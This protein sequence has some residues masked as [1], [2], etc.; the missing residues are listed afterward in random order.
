MYSAATFEFLQELADNNQRDWFAQH[1]QRYLSDVLAPSLELVRQLQKPLARI[2]PFLVADPRRSGGSVLRIYRDTRFSTDK[3]PYK[4]HVGIQ[5]RHE[6]G[7]DIHAPSIYIQ[8][9]PRQSLIAAGCYRPAPP[10]LAAIRSSIDA[11]QTAWKRARDDRKMRA[12]AE[13]WG[14]SLKTSP[15]DFPKS[16]PLIEDLKR[17]DFLITFDLTPEQVVSDQLPSF[18]LEKI[19]LSRSYMRFL[20]GALGAPY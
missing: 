10:A 4:T 20:C 13:F 15:R 16:H 14:D 1:K 7:K 12:E 5:L 18:L 17:K 8:I 3:T 6:A 2:A 11:R 19:K 9:D